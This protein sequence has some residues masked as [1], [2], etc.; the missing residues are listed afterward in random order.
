MAKKEDI[1]R[2]QGEATKWTK[3]QFIE[4]RQEF[5]TPKSALAG[6]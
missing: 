4:A 6:I 2:R 3:E 1:K 5:R